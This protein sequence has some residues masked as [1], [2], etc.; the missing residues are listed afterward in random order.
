MGGEE[1][2]VKVIGGKTIGKKT[3]RKTKTYVGG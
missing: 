3:T 1:G 2:Y